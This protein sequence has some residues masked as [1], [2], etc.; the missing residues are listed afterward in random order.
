MCNIGPVPPPEALLNFVKPDP[1]DSSTP[2]SQLTITV[3]A[4]DRRRPHFEMSGGVLTLVALSAA[5]ATSDDLARLALAATD[6]GTT[7][8]GIIVVNPDAHDYSTGDLPARAVRQ[9]SVPRLPED[10]LS[11][12]MDEAQDEQ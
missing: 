10:S 11:H 5:V 6:A 4:V 2:Q 9:P 7:L 12:P 1:T 8:D 3:V